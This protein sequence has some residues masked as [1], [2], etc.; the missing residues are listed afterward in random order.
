VDQVLVDSHVKQPDHV[1][2]S[3]AVPIFPPCGTW[4]LSVPASRPPGRES[5]RSVALGAGIQGAIIMGEPIE[6][7]LVDVTP[8]RWALRWLISSP[9]AGCDGSFQA[10]NPS[11]HDH[12]DNPT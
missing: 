8:F 5:V 1:L 4:S 12:S 2:L 7:I 10:A 3:A 6:A 11:Q 9:W